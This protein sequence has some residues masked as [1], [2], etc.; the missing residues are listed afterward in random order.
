MSKNTLL[1][2]N[3]PNMCTKCS[4]YKYKAPKSNCHKCK[5]NNKMNKVEEYYNQKGIDEG[6]DNFHHWLDCFDLDEQ[7]DKIFKWTNEYHQSRVKAISDEDIS[8]KIELY[9]KEYGYTM[10]DLSSENECLCF[11]GIENLIE[12]FKEQLLK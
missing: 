8:N 4:G 11:G 12:W 3:P 5:C 6:Y 7:A 1:P 2:H 10:H 9:I